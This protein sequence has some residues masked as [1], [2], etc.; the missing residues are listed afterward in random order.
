MRGIARS[1]SWPGMVLLWAWSGIAQAQAAV[2][3]PHEPDNATLA[4]LTPKSR[5][6]SAIPYPKGALELKHGGTVRVRIEF[7][8][9]DAA[10]RINVMYSAGPD[11]EAAVLERVREYRLPCFKA[12]S[13]PIVVTQEFSFDPRDGRPVTW[14]GA[15]LSRTLP[16]CTLSGFDPSEVSY[17]HEALMRNERGAVLVLARFDAP[18]ERPT[19]TFLNPVESLDLARKVR[20]TMWRA[21]LECTEAPGQ[22]PVIGMMPFTFRIEGR[23]A[24]Q[25]KDMSLKQFVGAIDQIDKHRVRF[26]LTSMSCPFDVDLKLYQPYTE[27][28]VGEVGVPNPNRQSFLAWLRTVAL[29]IPPVTL[30]QVLGDTIRISVPCGLVDLTS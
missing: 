24:P 28:A 30:K 20:A 22:W 10:P 4:C 13:A 29:R 15:Q 18:G 16:N 1:M 23:P 2:M 5:D 21:R 3:L 12:G 19:V 8:S 17:P 11:F 9:A 6:G 27:N 7:F 25:L 26:D 14:S